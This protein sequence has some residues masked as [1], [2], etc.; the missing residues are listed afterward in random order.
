MFAPTFTN[1]YA[2]YKGQAAIILGYWCD[3]CHAIGTEKLG[4]KILVALVDGGDLVF[5]DLLD[6]KLDIQKLKHL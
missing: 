1:Y 5:A 3:A 6:V 4:L 2:T